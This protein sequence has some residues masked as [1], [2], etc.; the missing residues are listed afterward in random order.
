MNRAAIILITAIISISSSISICAG[1]LAQ[2]DIKAQAAAL[3]DADSGRILWGKNADEPLPMASTTKIMTAIIALE[4]GRLSDT[5]TVSKKAAAAPPVKMKLSTNE[6][7]SLENLLYALMLQSSNDAAVAIAEHIGGTTEGFAAVMNRKAEE[8]GCTDTVFVTPNGLDSDNHHS[9]AKDMAII[10]KYALKNQEFV[11]IINTK[12]INFKSDIKKY[13]IINKNRLLYEYDGAIGIKTGYTGKAGHCFVGAAQKNGIT[14][15]SVV[16]ASGWGN[17]GK[18]QKWTDTKKLLNYCFENYHNKT[19]VKK[20]TIYA[21]INVKNG[22]QSTLRL[23]LKSDASMP[24]T[25][26]EEKN[27]RL[28][29]DIPEEIEAPV[30]QGDVMGKAILYIGSEPAAVIELI[31]EKS[32]E[33]HDFYTCLKKILYRWLDMAFDFTA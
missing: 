7:I 26:E 24:I 4:N 28:A 11:K 1:Q 17:S 33:R 6:K 3:I 29:A 13:D 32:I 20:N 12:S 2:S 19:I 9:T 31:A 25:D 23:L 27:I 15:I 30:S 16:L 8:I 5:V 22:T 14:A 10:A 21:E 18:Q